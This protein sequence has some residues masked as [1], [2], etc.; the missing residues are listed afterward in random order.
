VDIA[1]V[2][3]VDQQAL[4]RHLKSWRSRDEKHMEVEKGVEEVKIRCN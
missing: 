1:G 3:Q 2:P 4:G